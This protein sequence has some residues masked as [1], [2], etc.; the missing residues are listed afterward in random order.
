MKQASH[1]A[2]VLL[3]SPG[4]DPFIENLAKASN[5]VFY[6]EEGPRDSPRQTAKTW[7]K[8]EGSGHL[9][10]V[11]VI[12]SRLSGW[13]IHCDIVSPRLFELEAATDLGGGWADSTADC[14]F[15]SNGDG[16]CSICLARRPSLS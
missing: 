8:I 3:Y 9:G 4:I 11:F 6:F 1:E 15:P 13:G 16:V 7:Q 5:R 2:T 10:W 12:W 14:G